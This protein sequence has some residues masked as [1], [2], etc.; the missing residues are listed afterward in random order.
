VEI[1]APEKSLKAQLRWA[2][3]WGA[4]RVVIVGESELARGVVQLKDL[5]GH[6]QE[7]VGVADL[8]RRLGVAS[9]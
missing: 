7:E 9:R 8:L 6:A 2:D 1:G 5:A 4:G 3:G